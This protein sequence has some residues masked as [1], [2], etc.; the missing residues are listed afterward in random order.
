MNV[1][2]TT[3]SVPELMMPPPPTPVVVFPLN[4]VLVISAAPLALFD[5]PAPLPA[6]F[7]DSTTWLSRRV[8]AFRR[9]PPRPAVFPFWMET[10]LTWSVPPAATSRTRNNGVNVSRLSTVCGAPTRLIGAVMIG[11]P[12][13]AVAGVLMR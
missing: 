9:P 13:A 12:S 2:L 3:V 1:D 6:R 5:T 11:S 8:P 4:V 7:P 10:L